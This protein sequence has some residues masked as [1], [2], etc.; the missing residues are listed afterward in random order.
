MAGPQDI[1]LDGNVVR[2]QNADLRSRGS[3]ANSQLTSVLTQVGAPAG[4]TSPVGA[5][6]TQVLGGIPG[7]VTP[8]IQ[9][10]DTAQQ[11]SEQGTEAGVTEHETTDAENG[12]RTQAGQGL[13]ATSIDAEARQRA[14]ELTGQDPMSQVGQQVLQGATGAIQAGAQALQQ[15]GQQ[16]QQVGQQVGQTAQQGATQ[17]MSSLAENK[18]AADANPDL[19]ASP[20]LGGG[21]GDLGGG[22]LGDLGGAGGGLGGGGVGGVDPNSAPGS[23]AAVAPFTSTALAGAGNAN[24]GGA[25]VAPVATPSPTGG[26]GM[27]MVPPGMMNRGAAGGKG[28]GQGQQEGDEVKPLID[29]AAL[30]HVEQQLGAIPVFDVSDD[31]DDAPPFEAESFS[32]K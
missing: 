24:R 4:A 18:T 1:N 6:I 10:A 7:A 17:L 31:G 21:L 27:P 22:G 14:K 11:T 20:D 32:S 2:P 28:Q 9:A 26:S 13:D 8:Q 16:I 30:P 5:R 25:V 19:G 15:V 23:G 3:G 12:A 29:T